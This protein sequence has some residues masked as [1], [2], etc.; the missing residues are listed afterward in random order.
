MLFSM[1]LVRTGEKEEAKEEKQNV[2][3]FVVVLVCV[4]WWFGGRVHHAKNERDQKF[5]FM[6]CGC[7]A[8]RRVIQITS[9]EKY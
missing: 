7:S 8:S 9:S 1:V 5:K 3:P 4:W 2:L 6:E